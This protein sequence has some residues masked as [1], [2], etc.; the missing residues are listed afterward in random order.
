MSIYR[1]T[2]ET[3]DEAE[4][5]IAKHAPGD[6]ASMMTTDEM[7]AVL[8]EASPTVRDYLLGQ[9][10]SGYRCFMMNHDRELERLRAEVS[11]V[12]MADTLADTQPSPE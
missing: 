2:K 10:S 8:T 1:A 3:A 12:R 5:L 6:P 9:W 4:A 11:R 7:W